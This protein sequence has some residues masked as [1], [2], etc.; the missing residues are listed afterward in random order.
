MYTWNNIIKNI[1]SKY[2]LK[3]MEKEIKPQKNYKQR[4][5]E[6]R[7]SLYF[8]FIYRICSHD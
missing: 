5:K 4:L 1:A 8:L 6:G 3:L 2:F 7:Y